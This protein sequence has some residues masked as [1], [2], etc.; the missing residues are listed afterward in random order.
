M[1]T[2]Q[3][4]PSKNRFAEQDRADNQ[5]FMLILVGATVVLMVAMYFIFVG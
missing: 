2:K 1:A 3:Q 4:K 5:K